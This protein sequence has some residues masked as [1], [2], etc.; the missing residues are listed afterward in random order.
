MTYELTKSKQASQAAPAGGA[1][2]TS[3]SL[4]T[5]DPPNIPILS[6]NTHTSNVNNNS[7]THPSRNNTPH[8][9]ISND[10]PQHTINEINTS[11]SSSSLTLRNNS[12]GTLKTVVQQPS[13]IDS[14]GTSVNTASFDSLAR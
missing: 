6:S 4:I 13:E 1:A 9:N 5:A 7:N 10:Q 2:A 14:L 12:L 8:N 11:S 3:P